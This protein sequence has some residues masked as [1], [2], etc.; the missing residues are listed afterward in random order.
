MCAFGDGGK[1]S[2]SAALGYFLIA[3]F[4][5]DM[6]VNFNL[7]YY[8]ET[9]EI[10][11]DRKLIARHYWKSGMLFV[12]FLG[13]FPFYVVV[14]AI[15]GEIGNDNSL[16]RYLNLFRLIRVVRLY[17]VKQLYNVVRFS[18]QVSFMAL[19]LSRNFL[20]GLLWTHWNACIFYFIARQH[21]FNDDNTWIGGNVEGATNFERYITSLY[22][23]ITSTLLQ[24]AI[25]DMISYYLLKAWLR[26]CVLTA[27]SFSLRVQPL[28][29]SDME[30]FLLST[31]S[32]RFFA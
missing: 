5:L 20:A 8:D 15:S 19:T 24:K 22:W 7:A 30:I 6:A 28:L 25:L 14:L 29:P 26:P 16:T 32:N 31:K 11:W 23:S 3:V 21:N 10:I 13:V 2:G 18:T 9:D 27:V 17:R 4:L 1:A 12:D